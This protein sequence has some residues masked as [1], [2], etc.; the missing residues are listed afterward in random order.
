MSAQ[1]RFVR[2]VIAFLAAAAAAA[3]TA[4]TLLIG[5]DVAGGHH[6]ATPAQTA[7]QATTVSIIMFGY[8]VGFAALPAIGLT[9]LAHGTRAPRPWTDILAGAAIPVI[10]FTLV[11][12]LATQEF[13]LTSL[14]TW[15]RLSPLCAAGAVGGLV[16]AVMLGPRRPRAGR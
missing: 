12:G 15:R 10:V 5:L 1:T 3:V 13:V 9:W 4:A 16:Y 8:I 11:F 7:A 2:P 14:R 6:R